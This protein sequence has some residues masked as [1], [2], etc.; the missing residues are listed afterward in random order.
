MAAIRNQYILPG[1]EE[2]EIHEEYHDD[3]G[4]G[5]DDAPAP[6]P[7]TTRSTDE[8]STLEQAGD[9]GIPDLEDEDE[10]ARERWLGELN[11]NMR[12]SR[13][14]L[15]SRRNTHNPIR[16]SLVGAL[17]FRAVLSS[18]K[19]SRNI[20]TTPIGLRRYSDDPTYN[21]A[22]SGSGI[23]SS[24]YLHTASS[25]SY[26]G[27]GSTLEPTNR[28]GNRV[29]A[30]STNDADTT[31]LDPSIIDR[32]V[33]RL[34][35][36][37]SAPINGQD[38]AA[39]G[40]EGAVSQGATL[41]PTRTIFEQGQRAS[42]PDRLAPPEFRVKRDQSTQPDSLSASASADNSHLSPRALPK[43]QVPPSS[44]PSPFPPYTDYPSTRS[45]SRAPSLRLPSPSA[46]PEPYFHDEHLLDD[47][48]SP[49][50]PR[51]WPYKALPAPDILLSTLFPT[52]THW[53]NKNIWERMLGVVAA[54][55][56]FLLT[57][58]L[59]VVDMPKSEEGDMYDQDPPSLSLPGPVTPIVSVEDSESRGPIRILEPEGPSDGR[60]NPSRALGDEL[61][62]NTKG[63]RSYF[64]SAETANDSAG[65]QSHSFVHSPEQLPS[66]PLEPA[67]PK[68]WNRWLVI[69]QAFTSPMFIVVIIWANTEPEYP[70]ALIRPI[71]YSLIFSLTMLAILITTTTPT[72]PPRWRVL[73]CFLGFVVS[74]S[75]ISTI[76]GEVVGVLKTLGV[77]LDMSDAILGLTIFAVGNSLGDLVADITVAR[78]GFPVMALSACFGGPMLNILL[79]IGIS[80]CYMTIKGSRAHKH[81]PEKPI[82]YKPYHLD[83]STTLVISG[84]T[85]L[86]TLLGLLVMV[87]SRK[88]KMDKMVGWCLV[89]LWTTSTVVNVV[90]EVMGWGSSV[91]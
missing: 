74:I 33:P 37:F 9:E 89:A 45:S 6:T 53:K 21:T 81:H 80:G 82:K 61:R 69:L 7:L 78:L 8:F 5:Y 75:W 90:V 32:P 44:P 40:A 38:S 77:I 66:T 4:G 26:R 55:S 34:D 22:H 64:D 79:G 31:Q 17:E 43:I 60:L 27:S 13:P 30:V 14:R 15:G 23:Q 49:K 46:S 41:S 91:S 85:L 47:L 19:K 84:A 28:T 73:L 86:A 83:I 35:F 70:R 2:E 57:M 20:Q 88:W 50:M 76:A 51:W 62:N 63:V 16:P 67:E 56:V 54:P 48:P 24:P 10:D 87:P 36:G 52:L 12:L 18:L 25:Q 71:L 72:R 11:S 29:R 58:T 65:V 1:G 42:S 59:P 39:E 3:D 68:Q